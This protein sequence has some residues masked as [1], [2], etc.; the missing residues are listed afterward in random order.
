M[1]TISDEHC[2]KTMESILG[3]KD[4]E[5][6]VFGND[7]VG[8]LQES[9]DILLAYTSLLTKDDKDLLLSYA[10]KLF[11]TLQQPDDLYGVCLELASLVGHYRLG[12]HKK[13]TAKDYNDTQLRSKKHKPEERVTAFK[14]KI[15]ELLL[16]IGTHPFKYHERNMLRL[17]LLDAYSDP[18]RYIT[19]KKAL[20]TVNKDEI[21][22]YLQGL[23]LPGTIIKKFKDKIDSKSTPNFTRFP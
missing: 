3:T 9:E 1:N 23:D 20:P 8:E 18:E 2:T 13:E 7:I 16:F 17:Q 5:P 21:G 10:P 15:D 12:L 4:Y 22:E 11:N 14:T 6:F 19:Q